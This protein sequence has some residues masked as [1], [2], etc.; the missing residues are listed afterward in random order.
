MLAEWAAAWNIP[1]AAMRDFY[2]RVG[3]LE[4]PL[5]ESQGR[6][7]SNVSSR[8]RLESSKRGY[9]FWRNNVGALIDDRGVPVRYGLANDSKQVNERLKSG[10]LIA[11]QPVLIEAHH[12]GTR[13]GQFV[14]A[15]VKREDWKFTGTPREIAQLNWI[16]LVNS[17]GG[18]AAFVTAPEQLP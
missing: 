14:S 18:W 15:E 6:S 3:A 4:E 7:E 8:L 17:R 10:D 16:N 2:R 5:A 1:P 9:P 11:C 13:I 12:V